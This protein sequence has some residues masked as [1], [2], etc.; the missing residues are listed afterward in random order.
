MTILTGASR[1]YENNGSSTAARSRVFAAVFTWPKMSM[2]ER[3][4]D[5]AQIMTDSFLE[6]SR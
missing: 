1:I 3:S 5:E 2:S 6:V 4:N